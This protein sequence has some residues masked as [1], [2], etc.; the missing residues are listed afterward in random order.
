MTRLSFCLLL[1]VAWLPCMAAAQPS[2]E[3]MV[4]ARLALNLARFAQR[5]AAA[6]SEP[7][8]LCL[9]HRDAAFEQAFGELEGKLVNGRRIV[10]QKAPPVQGCDVLYVHASA[11]RGAEL[12]RACQGGATLTIGDGEGF[13]AHGGMVELVVVNDALRFDVNLG[14]VRQAQLGLSSQVLKLARQVKE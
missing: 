10:L 3:L 5:P 9:A 4:K 7:L 13:L 12:V 6:A 8:R 1:G 14:P 2:Q 11:D